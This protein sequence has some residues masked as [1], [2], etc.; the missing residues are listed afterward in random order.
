MVEREHV[1]VREARMSNRVVWLWQ[2][3]IMTL[4]LVELR[5]VFARYSVDNSCLDQFSSNPIR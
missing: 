2:V 5:I 3:M 4:A 1:P